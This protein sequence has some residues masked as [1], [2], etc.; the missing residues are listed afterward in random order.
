MPLILSFSPV[1]FLKVQS[2]QMSRSFSKIITSESKNLTILVK[3]YPMIITDCFL[4]WISVD[5]QTKKVIIYDKVSFRNGTV[6]SELRSTKLTFCYFLFCNSFSSI[7]V[8][9]LLISDIVF[10]RRSPQM[11]CMT[12]FQYKDRKLS[13]LAIKFTSVFLMFLRLW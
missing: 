4:W 12:Y 2:Q 13:E 5:K 11:L 3:W 9:K 1:I 10:S 7:L 8:W 6:D